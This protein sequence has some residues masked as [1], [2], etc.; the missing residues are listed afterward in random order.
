MVKN[1]GTSK[2]KI[3]GF[4]PQHNFFPALRKSLRIKEK[5]FELRCYRLAKPGFDHTLLH[6]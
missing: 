6:A 3:Q 4:T 1:V 2:Y 5:Y